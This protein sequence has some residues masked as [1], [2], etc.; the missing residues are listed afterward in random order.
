MEV[1]QSE[2]FTL[3]ELMRKLNEILYRDI[4]SFGPK[5]DHEIWELLSRRAPNVTFEA[6]RL[7]LRYVQDDIIRFHQL[8]LIMEADGIDANICFESPEKVNQAE[9]K[10]KALNNNNKAHLIAMCDE[11]TMNQMGR[12]FLAHIKPACPSTSFDDDSED[13]PTD[14]VTQTHIE[15]PEEDYS[16][17]TFVAKRP[18]YS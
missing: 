7:E 11:D 9:E 18:R 4:V 6:I 13:L 5:N 17:D 3:R 1:S 14:S 16:D 2:S 10:I 8:I 15:A 12:R